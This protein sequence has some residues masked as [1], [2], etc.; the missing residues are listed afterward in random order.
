MSLELKFLRDN[1]TRNGFHFDEEHY[2]KL[3]HF[4]EFLLE[5]NQAYNLIS[6]RD[7]P[8]IV[9]RH[10]VESLGVLVVLAI[11]KDSLVLDVGSG[12]GFP[13]VPMKILR[14]D[15]QFTLFESNG[16]KVSF[17]KNVAFKLGLSGFAVHERRVESV[18]QNEIP[19]Q[20]FVTARSVAKLHIL[21]KWTR[22]LLEPQGSLLAMKG[23]DVGSEISLMSNFDDVLMISTFTFPDWLAIERSRLLVGVKKKGARVGDAQ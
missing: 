20:S 19:A 17:L 9:T 16:K 13:A 6:R 2:N 21:W 1:C 7:E 15:L 11:P 18:K 4:I 12:A 8:N 5:W 3:A 22:D 23:G 14:P 10:I